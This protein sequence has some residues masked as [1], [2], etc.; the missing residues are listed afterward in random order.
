M[1]QHRGV[2]VR[3]ALLG[4]RTELL[5]SPLNPSLCH[6]PI[7]CFSHS[8]SVFVCQTWLPREKTRSY[9]FSALLRAS[10]LLPTLLGRS[11]KE[12]V[13]SSKPFL[14]EKPRNLLSEEYVRAVWETV[15]CYQR[16]LAVK[17]FGSAWACRGRE[18]LWCWTLA[19]GMHIQLCLVHLPSPPTLPFLLGSFTFVLMEWR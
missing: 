5:R 3:T 6:K 1:T 2:R 18:I 16:R 11:R 7:D 13:F 8:L 12:L 10:P 14:N 17:R 4:A 15:W 19:Q 9:I